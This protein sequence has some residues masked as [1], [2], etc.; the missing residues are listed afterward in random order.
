MFDTKFKLSLIIVS[1]FVIANC[2]GSSS[3]SELNITQPSPQSDLDKHPLIWE[4]ASLESVGF[5]AGQFYAAIDYA[6][7]DGFYT[8]SVV[9]IKDGYLVYEGY[10]GITENEKSNLIQNTS[11]T[12]AEVNVLYGNRDFTSLST[13]WSTA[14][15]FTSFLVGIAIDEGLINNI[16]QKAADFISEWSNDDR[17]KIS[18][19]NLLDMRSNLTQMCFGISLAPCSDNDENGGNLVFSND[20]MTACINR[21]LVNPDMENFLEGNFNYSNCDTMVLGEILFRASGMDLQTYAENK[22]F[23]R[24]H[25]DAEWWRDSSLYGQ[26][27]GNYLAYCCLDS[28][29]RDFAKFGY[30]ILQGGIWNNGILEYSNYTNMI[31]NINYYG[32]QFWTLPIYGLNRQLISTIGFDGQY[33][34]I[35]YLNNLVVVR[36]SLYAHIS[37]FSSQKKMKISISDAYSG[38]LD[39]SN[40]IASLPN[41]LGI[42][43]QSGFGQSYFMRLLTDSLEN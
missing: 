31:R 9:I 12:A 35:D 5:D 8:Q 22:L 7:Q 37:N 32:L 28:T 39:N 15:S 14:K 41:G 3:Q 25:I 2:G 19:K 11:M 10:R 42:D 6:F 30:M 36:T 27:S 17:N 40:W 18:I 33:I 4:V 43:A 26:A 1:L 24:I 23:S 21:N 20:Q 34:T 29:G 16:D 38:N 13:S